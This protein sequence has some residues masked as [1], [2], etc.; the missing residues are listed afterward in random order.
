MVKHIIM[1]DISGETGS[2]NAELKTYDEKITTLQTK[3]N[4]AKKKKNAS[5]EKFSTYFTDQKEKKVR[6]KI[7]KTFVLN[8]YITWPNLILTMEK[9]TTIILQQ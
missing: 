7:S 4:D 2:V 3:W 9:K 1:E 8:K 6:K 5:L